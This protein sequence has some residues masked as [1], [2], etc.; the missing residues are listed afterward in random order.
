M[1]VLSFGDNL[2][3]IHAYVD[4]VNRI[5]A[6][7]KEKKFVEGEEEDGDEVPDD[8][9]S[10]DESEMERDITEAATAFVDCGPPDGE[11]EDGDTSPTINRPVALPPM[12][13]KPSPKKRLNF[14]D[15]PSTASKVIQRKEVKHRT[16]SN[17]YILL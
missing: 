14:D 15:P 7:K 12:P 13:V 6:G 4:Q 11:D 5:F 17:S 1:E 2:T 10:F 3:W 9:D 8:N 16:S